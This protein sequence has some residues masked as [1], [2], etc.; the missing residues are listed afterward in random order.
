[1]AKIGR[2]TTAPRLHQIVV[3]LTKEEYEI[4]IEFCEKN[5]TTT[6]QAVSAALELLRKQ[7]QMDTKKE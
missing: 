3:R 6:T 4:I 2:P 5:G 1:M 7:Q